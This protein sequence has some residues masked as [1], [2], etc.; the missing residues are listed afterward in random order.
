[1][2]GLPIPVEKA[3]ANNFGSWYGS[4]PNFSSFVTP[5]PPSHCISKGNCTRLLHIVRLT[6]ML[7]FKV[8]D[9]D[10]IL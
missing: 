1:M 4:R 3:Y 2:L 6:N 9:A 7:A 5:P 8:C 10:H